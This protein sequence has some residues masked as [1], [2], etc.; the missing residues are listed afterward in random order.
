MLKTILKES[1]LEILKTD[2][3]IRAQIATHLDKSDIQVLR[4]VRDEARILLEI[5]VLN[6]IANG[7]GKEVSEITEQVPLT[8]KTTVL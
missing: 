3:V 8:D 1:V 4:Y 6:I 7:V 2:K 5:D